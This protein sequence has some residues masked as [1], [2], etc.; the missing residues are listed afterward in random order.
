V[1]SC[2]RFNLC[3]KTEPSDAANFVRKWGQKISDGLLVHN[4]TA[5][6][7]FFFTYCGLGSLVPADSKLISEIFFCQLRY[8]VIQWSDRLR[9]RV[10]F[11][12][13]EFP[14]LHHVRT[15]SVVHDN[16]R[17]YGYRR[18]FPQGRSN[19]RVKLTRQ[20]HL[21]L[22]FRIHEVLPPQEDRGS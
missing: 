11:R 17:S 15:D 2:Y 13:T 16:L 22:R 19:C 8:P 14:L 20:L 4:S 10:R 1:T 7:L 3:S 18:F 21:M 12:G 9:T 6:F 5:F